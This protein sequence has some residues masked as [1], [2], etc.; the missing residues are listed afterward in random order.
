MKTKI[1]HLSFDLDGTLE[2]GQF[3]KIIWNVEI[4]KLYSKEHNVPLADAERIVFAEYYKALYIENVTN[5]TDISM[6]FSRLG[7]SDWQSL[8]HDMR[9]YIHLYDDALPALQALGKKYQ[10]IMI[11][12][13]EEKFLTIKLDASGIKDKF[14]KIISSNTFLLTKKDKRMYE[15]ALKALHIA[16]AQVLHIGDERHADFDVPSSIGMH[17]LLIDRKGGQSGPYVI[18]S[19]SEIVEKIKQIENDAT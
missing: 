19:L 8:L 14:N 5:W 16:P 3:D 1:T 9:K 18:H 10:L 11:S 17:A 12:N 2:F 15:Q 6:W 13:S 4:P 7:L